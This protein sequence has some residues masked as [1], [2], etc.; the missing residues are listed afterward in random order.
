MQERSWVRE[1]LEHNPKWADVDIESIWVIAEC[2]CGKCKTVFFDSDAPQN[3]P[4][5][6][7]KGWVGRIEIRTDDDFGITVAL[8]QLN[9]KLV[10][11]YVDAVDLREPGNRPF[12]E[13]WGERGRTVISI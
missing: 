7:T 13:C 1:I 6:R 5:A 9:G 8:D 10:G 4:L 3:P 12:P 11:L 2:D